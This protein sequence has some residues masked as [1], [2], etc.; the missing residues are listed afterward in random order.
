MKL[1][2]NGQEQVLKPEQAILSSA[3]SLFLN[4]NQAKSSFAVAV[5]GDFVS[6]DSY[7]NTALKSND[8]IDVLF[9]IV[10]G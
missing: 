3:L 7:S 9:P 1:Y 10:G 4:D 5:N 2:I 6:K 8:S